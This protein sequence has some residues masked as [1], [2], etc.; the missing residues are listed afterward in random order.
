MMGFD[1]PP[2]HDDR[3]E[4]VALFTNP[5]AALPGLEAL[6]AEYGGHAWA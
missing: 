5:K 2:D 3:P 4:V 1:S 6:L